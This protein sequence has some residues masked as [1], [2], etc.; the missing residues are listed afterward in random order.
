M[1]EQSWRYFVSQLY[2]LSG[3]DYKGDFEIVY[4]SRITKANPSTIGY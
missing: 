3:F 2:G 1:F 4:A